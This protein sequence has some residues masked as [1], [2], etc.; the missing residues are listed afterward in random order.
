MLSP[1]AFSDVPSKVDQAFRL[2]GGVSLILLVGITTAMIMLAVKFRRGRAKTTSQ[3]GGNTLLEITW[4]VIPTV[5]VMWM[6]FVGYEGF[7]IMRR[8]PE[9]HM[10]I[11]VTGRQWAWSFSYP[12]AQIDTTEMVVPVNT[13]ILARLT[14]PP[15]DVVHSFYI[16]AFRVKEDALPGRET[17]MW[18][19]PRHEGTYT[20][21]CAEFCGKDHSKMISL[22][23]VVSPE[24]FRQWIEDQR[25]RRFRPLEFD[26]VINPADPG[27]G[28][29]GLNID[30]PALYGAYCAACHGL[31]GD[32][33]GLPGEAR[34]FTSPSGW[35]RSPKVTDIYRTLSEGIDG[36]RMRA[37]S[38]LTPW[39]RVALAHRVRK[40]SKEPLPQDTSEDYDALV[41]EYGLDR[42]QAPQKT[43]P[44][45]RA[46]EILV[47]EANTPQP[48]EKDALPDDRP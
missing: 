39:E 34:N 4:T 33:A 37:Y 2:I 10:V 45:E 38:N 26:A 17:S 9:N 11:N 23:K 24:K 19:E 43:I 21:L 22:L 30:A 42:V 47:R 41:A 3:V 35:K 29:D 7:A 20:I 13:P 6:F 36:T 18:F 16:P 27:F 46:M 5:I 40:F 25:L 12:E 1:L 44:V 48:A 15:Q 31:A 14:A 8:V 28:K 32:G